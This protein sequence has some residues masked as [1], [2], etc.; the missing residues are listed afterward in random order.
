MLYEAPIVEEVE[1]STREV[2]TVKVVLVAPA[3]MVTLDGTL[4]AELL[5]ES[6]ILAPPEGAGALSVTAPVDDS[7]PPTT[8]DGLRVSEV[9]VGSSTGL[10]VR[11]A[12][13]VVPA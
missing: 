6:V 11:D 9:T 1:I 3:G 4:A 8:L 12:A 2:S 10:T 7:S 5:L 13:F